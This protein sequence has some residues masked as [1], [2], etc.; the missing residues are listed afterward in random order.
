MTD[1]IPHI[2]SLNDEELVH[3]LHDPI[4]EFETEVDALQMLEVLG[5]ELR[6][7]REQVRHCTR[8]IATA[9]QAARRITEDG[10]PVSKQ[11]IIGATGLA[12]QT[13]YLRRS[14]RRRRSTG[15]A[16]RTAGPRS[17]GS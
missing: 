13:V 5:D 4:F 6:A 12:R 1:R 15:C 16:G 11:A 7:A 17:A 14:G 2:V 3:W 9:V 8:Y 10:K